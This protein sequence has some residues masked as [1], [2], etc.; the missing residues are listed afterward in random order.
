MPSEICSHLSGTRENGRFIA[1]DKAENHTKVKETKIARA[2]RKKGGKEKRG[3]YTISFYIGKFVKNLVDGRGLFGGNVSQKCSQ[4]YST[5]LK[6]KPLQ[7]SKHHCEISISHKSW[8]YRSSLINVH[9]MIVIMNFHHASFGNKVL[10]TY[11]C[12]GANQK[13]TN[14]RA[15]YGSFR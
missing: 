13:P 8:S 9:S 14:I 12:F 2:R 6:L 10:C 15:P 11:E 5:I 7:L 3:G 1:S 4:I